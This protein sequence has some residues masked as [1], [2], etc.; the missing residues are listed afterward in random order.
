MSTD[1]YQGRDL[2]RALVH[3][4]LMVESNWKT[5][6]QAAIDRDGRSRRE[7]S[8]AA[9]MSYNFI[10]QMFLDGKAPSIENFTK[11]CLT[12]GVSP[13]YVLTGAEMTPETEILLERWAK[14][15]SHRRRALLS[16]LSEDPLA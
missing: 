9:G 1:R 8:T 7:I 6:L 3:E 4:S 13:I 16:L 11:L 15:P 12:L 14:V 10:S 5:R 2:F